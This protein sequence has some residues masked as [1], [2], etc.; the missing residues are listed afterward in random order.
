MPE[1]TVI[2]PRPDLTD[3]TGTGEGEWIVIVFNNDHNTF[4]E[5]TS[6]LQ[7]ATGCT[8]SEAEMETWEVHHLGRS[9]VHHA[10]RPECERVATVIRTIGI[11][12]EVGEL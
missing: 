10:E 12:V 1:Q 11:K 7:Q 3:S 8:Q 9:I 4:E 2:L 6:I 5:V